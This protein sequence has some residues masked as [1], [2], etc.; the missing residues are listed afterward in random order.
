M[1]ALNKKTFVLALQ[2]RPLAERANDVSSVSG[3]HVY[4]MAIKTPVRR[5]AHGFAD[6]FEQPRR[7]LQR[8]PAPHGFYGAELATR[9]PHNAGRQAQ[10]KDHCADAE[11]DAAG[12]RETEKRWLI[13]F[14]K[15]TQERVC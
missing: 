11:H 5:H 2:D 14:H 3:V 1:H 7:S 4:A 9:G 10:P 12:D 15:K 13:V 8:R 6:D